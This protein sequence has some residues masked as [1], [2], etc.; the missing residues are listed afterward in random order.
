M[1]LNGRIHMNQELFSWLNIWMIVILASRFFS[2]TNDITNKRYSS[3]WN[4]V[5]NGFVLDHSVLTISTFIYMYYLFIFKYL[6]LFCLCSIKMNNRSFYSISEKRMIFGISSNR[7]IS[8]IP[9]WCQLILVYL[10]YLHKLLIWPL[11]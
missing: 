1:L 11:I 4:S 8:L 6:C 9:A 7:I 5:Q 2:F 10:V 3:Q